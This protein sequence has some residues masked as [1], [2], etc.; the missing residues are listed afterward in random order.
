MLIVKHF[1]QKF[2]FLHYQVKKSDMIILYK[3][4]KYSLV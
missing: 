2:Y 3:T 4:V 1:I